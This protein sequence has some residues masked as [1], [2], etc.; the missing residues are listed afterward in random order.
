MLHWINRLLSRP[1]HILEYEWKNRRVHSSLIFL[2]IWNLHVRFWVSG[3]QHEPRTLH[4]G[5]NVYS[6]CDSRRL[7]WIR[8]SCTFFNRV[9]RIESDYCLVQRFNCREIHQDYQLL[10]CFGKYLHFFKG[11]NDPNSQHFH[12]YA[13]LY[14]WH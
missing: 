7:H 8:Q 1:E 10:C 5:L 4:E 9:L 14:R 12:L 13:Y 3:L 6:F 11:K 2:H